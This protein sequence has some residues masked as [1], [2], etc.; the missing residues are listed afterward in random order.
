[1]GLT[2]LFLVFLNPFSHLRFNPLLSAHL[3]RARHRC[4]DAYISVSTE[5]GPRLHLCLYLSVGTSV[6]PGLAQRDPAG[7][8]SAVVPLVLARLSTSGGGEAG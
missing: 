3:C 6:G 7:R 2:L 5:R 4:V 8:P 1:M